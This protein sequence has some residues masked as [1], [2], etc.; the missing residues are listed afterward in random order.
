MRST[1]G[2]GK[3]GSMNCSHACRWAFSFVEASPEGV[4]MLARGGRIQWANAAA[5]KLFGVESGE[6]KNRRFGE[7]FPYWV[8]D[9]V[10]TS[11]QTWTHRG[12]GGPDPTEQEWTALRNNRSEWPVGVVPIFHSAGKST[13]LSLQLRDLSTDHHHE[14]RM[15]NVRR[16][17]WQSAKLATMG[18]MA[19][20][21]AH[22]INN[23]LGI[24]RG[25]AQSILKDLSSESDLRPML[26]E[27][28]AQSGRMAQTVARLLEFCRA[29]GEESVPLRIG[30]PVEMAVDLLSE[31]FRLAGVGLRLDKENWST[32]V[33]GNLNELSQ[34][35]VNLLGNALDASR[36]SAVS[37]PLVDVQ[38]YLRGGAAVVGVR[39]RG[40]GI[41]PEVKAKLGEAF[42]TTKPVGRGTGLGLAISMEIIRAH[43]GTLSLENAEDV[44]AVAEVVLP[45]ESTPSRDEAHQTRVT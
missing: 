14:R 28:V 6:L 33:R 35:F 11:L 34:V 39:D 4:V 41:R 29:P 9:T 37:R 17:L 15:A 20:S 45:T 31:Q 1:R 27:V 30:K 24:V 43:G 42:F 44:G 25:Y 26:D 8:R 36:T 2:A 21:V 22:E 38:V 5:V 18:Q 12:N 32:V 23:P 3:N 13:I 19:A 16:E 7:L 40:P 10:E